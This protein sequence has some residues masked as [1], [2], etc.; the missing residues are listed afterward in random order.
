[1]NA[2]SVLLVVALGVVCVA[3]SAAADTTLL[4]DAEEWKR[5]HRGELEA[6]A[7]SSD[8]TGD[9]M[10]WFT[11]DAQAGG[12]TTV[13]E[14]LPEQRNVGPTSCW[15]RLLERFRPRSSTKAYAWAP[16]TVLR[17][18]KNT[19]P[20]E[21]ARTT[22][23][24]MWFE[25]A[26]AVPE[27]VVPWLVATQLAPA[28]PSLATCIEKHGKNL[29]QLELVMEGAYSPRMRVAYL[30]EQPSSLRTTEEKNSRALGSCFAERIM[31]ERAR[32]VWPPSLPKIEAPT[33]DV[34]FPT[35]MFGP[36]P[37]MVFVRRNSR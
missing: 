4:E 28:L 34:F 11:V 19:S 16:C 24:E 26:D 33:L 3:R 23:C 12:K 17:P 21:K 27:R 36:Q 20:T 29:P 32:L 9:F 7:L 25:P 5:A 37:P 1:M 31:A 30:R 10:A 18:G 6:C 2:R 13:A 14:I 35:A 15:R 8:V 22:L